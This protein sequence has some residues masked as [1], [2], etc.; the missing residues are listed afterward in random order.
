[1]TQQPQV[2]IVQTQQSRAGQNAFIVFLVTALIAFGTVLAY[3]TVKAEPE[4]RG[5]IIAQ[6]P[7]GPEGGS[8][9]FG[10]GGKIK[11]PEGAVRE[12]VSDLQDGR[13]RLRR[14]KW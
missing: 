6:L 7:V 13:P 14:R 11:V 5:E 10:D 9:S 2:I 8:A 3:R 12:R 4:Q 1:M